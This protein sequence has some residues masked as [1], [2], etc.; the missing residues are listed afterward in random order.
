M[1]E[2][3]AFAYLKNM[4]DTIKIQKD[5]GI[6]VLDKTAESM[7]EAIDLILKKIVKIESKIAT[8]IMEKN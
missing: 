4:C 8:S 3:Q 6:N 5:L 2:E 7:F 1:T